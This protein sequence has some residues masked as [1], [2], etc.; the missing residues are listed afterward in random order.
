MP[1]EEALLARLAGAGPIAAIISERIDWFDRPHG[2][3]SA[4]TLTKVD[5]GRE[6]THDGPD[7]LDEPRVRFE[8]WSPTK[9]GVAALARAVAT[10]MEQPRDVDGVRFHPAALDLERWDQPTDLA[11]GET[12]FRVIQDWTFFFEELDQ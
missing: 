5:A 4:I 8:L 3:A 7:R 10:E 2:G 9:A 6:W 12:L 11:G 1:M